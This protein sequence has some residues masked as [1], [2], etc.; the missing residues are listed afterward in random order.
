MNILLQVA[1]VC[2]MTVI[3]I[4]YFNDRKSAVKQN[5]LYL[6]QSLAIFGSLF[7][8]IFSIV[9]IN[10]P[11]VTYSFFTYAICRLYLISCLVVVYFGLLYVLGDLKELKKSKLDLIK[12][13]A[14][15]VLVLASVLI[16]VLPLEIVYDPEGLNDF[17]SGI[18]IILTYGGTFIFMALTLTIAFLNRK[19]M[20]HKR[21][22]AVVIFISVWVFGSAVQGLF[23]YVLADLGII[24]L[25]VSFTETLGSLAIYIMLENPAFNVDRITGALTHR[26]FE[27][28]LN[29]CYRKNNEIEFFVV[30]YDSSIASQIMGYNKLARSL[31]K[32]FYEYKA[33]KI[34]KNDKNN[35]IIVRKKD[36]T[37]PLPSLIEGFKKELYLR[38]NI[39]TE[40][41]FKIFYFND[42]HLLYDTQD[43]LDVIDYLVK[44]MNKFS[45]QLTL[46][47]KEQ[48]DIIHDKFELQKKS[49]VAFSKG[50]IEVYLQP[51]YS[52]M[53][54]SFSAAEALVRL[55]DDDGKLIYPK[56]FIEDMEA[57]GRIIE[58]GKIVFEDVCKFISENNMELLKLQY[59]EVNL[60]AVQCMQEDLAETYI[61]IMKKYNVN[62]KYI[63]LEITETAQ[64]TRAILLKNMSI[65]NEYGVSFSLDDFGTGNSNL[66][67]VIEMPVEIVK[68]DKEMVNSFFENK[69]ASFVLKSAIN[70]IKGLGHKIV[71]EGIEKEK[72]VE[73][74]ENMDIDYIQG[75]FYSK[76]IS[77]NEFLDFIRANNY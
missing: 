25:S 28:Y 32:Q 2:V 23:N 49:D 6:Y 45:E 68:F 41:P 1:G 5:R 19:I 67:Y 9:L 14:L 44:N 17:T 18:P 20:Y 35:F 37:K 60:S 27:D 52:R 77:K 21:F 11:G 12:Y 50:N 64:S 39:I 63:N 40:I 73:L 3:F 61:N 53:H 48:I 56:D 36:Q 7:L 31:T 74:L 51:I 26:A 69:I 46:V 65:L 75:Y 34:F 71:F 16:L 76:P 43:C 30:D 42:I 8:D 29:T 55:I 24:I 59:I 62:P 33:F 57:D 72:Q 13:V 15:A 4:F 10:T 70:M 66:N 54:S 58:L 47:S 38:N 22:K